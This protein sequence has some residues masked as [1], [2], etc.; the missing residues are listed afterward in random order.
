MTGLSFAG[1]SCGILKKV[2]SYQMSR[3]VRDVLGSGFNCMVEASVFDLG[4]SPK[5]DIV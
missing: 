4:L 5:T 1:P 2:T 3:L